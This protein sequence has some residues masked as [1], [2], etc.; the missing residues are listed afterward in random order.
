NNNLNARGKYGSMNNKITR[1]NFLISMVA[2]PT[3]GLSLQKSSNA[4]AL[5][6]VILGPPSPALYP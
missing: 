3:V 6:D 1:R 2:I 5:D 4:M